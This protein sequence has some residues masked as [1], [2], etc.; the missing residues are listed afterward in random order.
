MSISPPAVEG[1]VTYTDAYYQ[2][3][4]VHRAASYALLPLFALQVAAGT[5]LYSRGSD[6]AEWA[7]IGH[8]IGATGVAALFTVNVATG[9]P[10]LVAG[11]KDPTFRARRFTHAA[12]MLTAT[13]GFIAT[14]LLAERA[15]G[16][17]DDR[18]LHRTVALT[19]V[20]LA[21]VSYV[22]MFDRF[23]RD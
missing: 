5:Q 4:D 18:S 8:R 3:L 22:I 10:N 21:T 1:D 9:L 6:A 15:E 13:A 17:P 14:G 16:S 11:W 19:S 2:R 23:R 7:K 12:L 20:G